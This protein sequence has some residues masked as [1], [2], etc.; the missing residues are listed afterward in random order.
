MNNNY[1]DETWECFTC[2]KKFVVEFNPGGWLGNYH[3]LCDSCAD[4]IFY[5]NVSIFHNA[6]TFHYSVGEFL[7][8]TA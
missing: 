7:L 5:D 2:G 4:S 3:P 8:Q 6:I 1:H